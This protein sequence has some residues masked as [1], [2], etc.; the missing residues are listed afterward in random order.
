M[1]R[2]HRNMFDPL[3]TKQLIFS[4]LADIKRRS[5]FSQD[6]TNEVE[7]SASENTQ[8]SFKQAG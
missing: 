6:P 1:D 4:C 3:E 8:R 7:E 2:F 5:R